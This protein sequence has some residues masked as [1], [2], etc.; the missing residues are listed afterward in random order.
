VFPPHQVWGRI[1]KQ[2]SCVMLFRP[3][4]DAVFSNNPVVW[5]CFHFTMMRS[6]LLTVLWCG[7]VSTIPGLRVYFQTI[8][9][10]GVSTTPSLRS[11]FQT[12]Q[13]CGGLSISPSLASFFKLSSWW[14]FRFT[15]SEGV[16]VNNPVVWCCTS[17]RSY[18]LTT[19][20]WGGKC[21]KLTGIEVVFSNNP[22]V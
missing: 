5:C 21:V 4:H 2:S 14:S 20:L 13:L 11:Y 17:L 1:F 15:M 3:H 12:V 19:Y 22:I 6:Y 8:Q 18:F 10:C 7:A 9:F 16:F